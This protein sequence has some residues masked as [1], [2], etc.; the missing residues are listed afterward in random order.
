M[1][2]PHALAL[3][4]GLGRIAGVILMVPLAFDY[5]GFWGLISL[6]RTSMELFGGFALW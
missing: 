6:Y 3:T 5:V 1:I 2:E 4:D